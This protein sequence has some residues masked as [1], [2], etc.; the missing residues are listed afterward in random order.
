MKRVVTPSQLAGYMTSW[1]AYV[2]Y[3]SSH[4]DLEDPAEELRRRLEDVLARWPGGS[5]ELSQVL[6][7]IKGKR[8][9]VG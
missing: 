6:T 1:S 4:P 3:R 7:V 8:P 2:T 5:L 9:T